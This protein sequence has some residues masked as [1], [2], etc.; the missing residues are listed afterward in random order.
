MTCARFLAVFGVVALF[1]GCCGEGAAGS[2]TDGLPA[3]VDLIGS[4]SSDNVE[5]SGTS[6]GFVWNMSKETYLNP[7]VE[8]GSMIDS[9]DG[10]E[11]RT[12]IIDGMEWMAENLN[13]DPGQGGSGENKYDWSWC[14]D[15]EPKNCE[16]AGRLYTWAA[17]MDSVKTEC[18]YGLTCSP[19]L[20]VQGVCPSGWH[21]P[22]LD[23]WKALFASADNTAVGFKLKT[24]CGWEDDGNGDDSFG[25]AG[26]PAGCYEFVYD[27]F[28]GSGGLA[29]FWSSTERGTYEAY[30]TGKDY[31]ERAYSMNLYDGSVN[32]SMFYTSRYDGY[33]VRC[34]KDSE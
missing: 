31:S 12:I 7:E 24:M 20:P 14:Y 32:A 29:Y 25:F 2:K 27:R 9:R 34:I 28:I 5:S 23:E 22:S 10:K 13:Y 33:S 15:N 11:Y 6:D 8:Y 21:L 30:S 17:A 4:S 19:T 26:F 18:G 1:V 3:E 16:V